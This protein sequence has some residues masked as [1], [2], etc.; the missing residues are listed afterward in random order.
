MG[1]WKTCTT[2]LHLAWRAQARYFI[3]LLVF[4]ALSGILPT[5]SIWSNAALI[6]TLT[7]TLPDRLL[8]RGLFWLL[9]LYAGIRLTEQLINPFRSTLEDLY[10]KRFSQFLQLLITKKAAT[11]DLAKFEDPEFHNHLRQA[12][13]QAAYRPYQMINQSMMAFSAVFSLLSLL[14][15]SWQHLWIFPVLLL[16]SF[17]LFRVNVYF[18]RLRLNFMLENT[19]NE[20]RADY[21]QNLLTSDYAAKDVRLLS[22][23]RYFYQN[24]RNLLKELFTKEKRL[25]KRQLWR[26]A[27]VQ[28]PLT[29]LPL[30]MI[31][32]GVNAVLQQSLSIGGFLLFSQTVFQL[33]FTILALISTANQLGEHYLFIQS[34]LSF[35]REQPDVEAP[36]TSAQITPAQVAAVPTL[37]VPTLEFRQVGFIYPDQ[38]TPTLTNLSFTIRPGEKVAL[39]G[40]NGAGKTTLVKLLAGLYHPSRGQISLGDQD[41]QQLDRNELRRHLS[42]TFQDYQLFHLPLKTNVELGNTERLGDQAWLEDIASRTGLDTLSR[43]LPEGYD[44]IL[45]RWVDRG[46]ELSGGQRQLV[47]VSR[48]LFRDAPILILDEPTAAMDALAE[49]RFFEDLLNHPLNQTQTILFISHRFSTIRRAERILVLEKGQL[50]EEGSHEQLMKQK[51]LYARMYSAQARFFHEQVSA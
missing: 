10:Q 37:A 28:V 17:L 25:A 33:Q 1:F 42:V 29:L 32:Y 11:L 6:D 35:F 3:A 7:Q 45:E 23:Q 27:L 9:L 19:P 38:T 46:H 44:T 24:Y 39:V 51:G 47:A 4:T 14:V 16:S 8:E 18:S 20:R 41:I 15:I 48:A 26:V 30:A 49:E 21:F 2:V 5:L 50:I 22:L 31:V 40:E 13:E 43:N 12:S 36:R 34:M